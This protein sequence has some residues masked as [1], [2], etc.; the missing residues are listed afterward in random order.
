MKQTKLT[1]ML[2]GILAAAMLT[3]CGSVHAASLMDGI[4][5]GTVDAAPLAEASA[6]AVTD[7][8]VRLFRESAS[9]G[10]STLISPLSVLSALAMT[11]NGA[12]GE[13]RAQ[14]ESV[15]G[16]TAEE[17]NLWLYS[18]HR[19]L[20][21]SGKYK[22]NL[23]NSIWFT[24]KESFTVNTDF[25]QLCADYYDAELYRLPFDEGAK[26][27]I[28]GWV[29]EETDGMIKEI[30]NEIPEEAVM[31]LVNALAFDAEWQDIYKE[32]QVRPGTFTKEDGT[33]REA[34]MMYSDENRYLEDDDAS[35][36]IKYYA[37]RK[38]AFAALLPDEGVSVAEYVQSLDGAS[39]RKMLLDAET[40]TVETA[41][42][43]FTC[44]YDVEMSAILKAMGMTNA[45]SGDL[46]DFSG[47]GHST[48]GDLCIS[49]VLH[50]TFIQVDEKGTKAGA[51]TAV[52]VVT[53]SVMM[54]PENV[55][56]VYLDRPFVYMLIDCE[57]MMPFFIGTLMD[58]EE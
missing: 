5:P 21:E 12:E 47:L 15:F 18:Y 57:T 39:L 6:D 20:P 35:G 40:V 56:R 10:E 1:M 9:D 34:E 8:A 42:P 32:S 14:M 58:V 30:I 16:M 26:S 45:F 44:E 22:L 7:F 33:V 29:K 49:R 3:G 43:K 28:N 19:T 27:A 52:E 48:E 37:D 36:F 25:L 41:I 23:A 13:T 4:K 50:K 17:L 46:A 24:D 2:A 55:K 53:E 51:A 54:L 38:Y 11:T 31:Y